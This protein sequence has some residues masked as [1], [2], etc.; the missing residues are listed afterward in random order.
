VLSRPGRTAAGD[1][2]VIDEGY[3]RRAAEAH[4]RKMSA[5][6]GVPLLAITAMAEYRACWVFFYQSARYLQTRNFLDCVAG[7]APILVDRVTGQ[8]HGTGTARS[9]E[10]YVAE[11]TA[12]R[13]TCA[14]CRGRDDARSP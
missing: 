2:P 11:F 6:P 13:H 4:L 10:H 1:E 7:N 14:L 9:I 8:I 3:A 12:G 5:E